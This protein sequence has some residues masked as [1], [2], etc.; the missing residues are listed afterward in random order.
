MSAVES[1]LIKKLENLGTPEA[2]ALSRE[3]EGMIKSARSLIAGGPTEAEKQNKE[4]QNRQKAY[5]LGL[6]YNEGNL[7]KG[8]KTSVR[9]TKK[10]LSDMEDLGINY[11]YEEDVLFGVTAVGAES[12]GGNRVKLEFPDGVKGDL[13]FR[14][15]Q[16]DGSIYCNIRKNCKRSE[17]N[18]AA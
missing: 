14:F 6:V 13:Y 16:E 9:L 18:K 8:L 2:S 1:N 4:I 17:E 10:D 15:F 12:H 3:L 7:R 5:I 11:Y